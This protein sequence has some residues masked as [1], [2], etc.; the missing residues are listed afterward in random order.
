MDDAERVD[1]DVALAQSTDQQD[2]VLYRPGQ[3][4]P[5]LLQ[6][7]MLNVSHDIFS[8]GDVWIQAGWSL[9]PHVA[10]RNVA[11]RNA[12]VHGQSLELHVDDVDDTEVSAV[13][14]LRELG[15]A[16]MFVLAVRAVLVDAEV[17]PALHQGLPLLVLGG[18]AAEKVGVGGLGGVGVR[19]EHVRAGAGDEDEIDVFLFAAQF[20]PHQPDAARAVDQP[21]GFRHTLAP[22][23]L[24]CKK[25][26]G[27]LANS[28]GATVAPNRSPGELAK[29]TDLAPLAKD[30]HI[31]E[32][33]LGVPRGQ[34]YFSC[35]FH[36]VSCV[37]R[38]VVGAPI[39][40]QEFVDAEVD[41]FAVVAQTRGS[42]AAIVIP[43]QCRAGAVGVRLGHDARSKA[44]ALHGGCR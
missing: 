23:D 33:S 8:L 22:V 20:C 42:I 28:I 39:A 11:F 43:D 18:A 29:T 34:A 38:A 3:F 19:V 21:V 10:E 15:G 7:A 41:P 40:D 26:V 30:A 1:P 12:L 16:A 27:G 24:P 36:H 31:A 44:A 2:A 17:D 6:A 35:R 5:L 25:D 4:V 9:P 13:E 32:Y 37:V 14:E